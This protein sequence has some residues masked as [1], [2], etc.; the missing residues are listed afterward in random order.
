MLTVLWLG[1][2]LHRNQ[3]ILDLQDPCWGILATHP[4]HM[5]GVQTL[6]FCAWQVSTISSGLQKT[7]EVPGFKLSFLLG[8]KTLE[9]RS[10]FW[11]G[12]RGVRGTKLSWNTSSLFERPSETSPNFS[13]ADNVLSQRQLHANLLWFLDAACHFRGSQG[14]KSWVHVKH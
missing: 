14:E 3:Q 12:V 10:Y 13:F 8:W 1:V 2:H 11:S 7:R 5:H 9:H 4:S 6:C